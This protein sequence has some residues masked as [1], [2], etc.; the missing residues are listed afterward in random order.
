MRIGKQ[1]VEVGEY[2][3]VCGTL[4]EFIERTEATEKLD[5]NPVIGYVQPACENPQWILWFSES[6]DALLYTQRDVNGAVIGEPIKIKA[7]KYSGAAKEKSNG[8]G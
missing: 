2:A 1:G 4:G 7:R 3:K 8:I 6:G 5:S